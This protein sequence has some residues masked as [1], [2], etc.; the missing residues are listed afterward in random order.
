VAA[1]V[2]FP[3]IMLKGK[4][5]IKARLRSFGYAL[6]GVKLFIREEHN[7]RIHLVAAFAAILCGVLLKISVLEWI[8]VIISIGFVL[9]LEILN[10]SVER[11]ADFVSPGTDNRI[12]F[13]KDL[14]AATV[15]VASVMAFAVGSFVFIPKII[16]LC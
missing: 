4:F 10:T 16:V 8:A 14:S 6:E 7:F 1:T 12:K 3:K 15:L 5:S 11:I 9:S 13:I 2:A